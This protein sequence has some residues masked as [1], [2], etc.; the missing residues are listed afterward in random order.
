MA[1]HFDSYFNKNKKYVLVTHRAGGNLA[2]ENSCR[3]REAIKHKALY[4]EI[5]VQRT[6]DDKYVI[7]HDKTFKRLC[8]VAKASN[9]MSLNEIKA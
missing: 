9:E 2:A 5:D 8:G 7:N 3:L 6:K 4:S 1:Y